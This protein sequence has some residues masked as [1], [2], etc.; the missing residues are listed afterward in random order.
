M[1]KCVSGAPF[2]LKLG[3]GEDSRLATLVA[4]LSASASSQSPLSTSVT[5]FHV[6]ECLADLQGRSSLATP[7]WWMTS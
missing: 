1:V 5:H 3:K 6:F 7:T 2:V 4:S